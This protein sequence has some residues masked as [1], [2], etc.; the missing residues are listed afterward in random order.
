MRYLLTYLLLFLQ[1]AITIAQNNISVITQHNDLYRT[2]WNKNETILNPANVAPG[3]FGLIASLNVDD[4]V[5]AQVLIVHNLTIGNFTGNVLFA[6]TVNNSVYAFNA[7]DVSYG[8]PLWQINLNP[9]GQRAPDIFDLKD[10]Q[11]GQPCGGNYRD[12]SGRMGIVG[13]PVIDT[14]SN[15]L[16][17]ATKTIDA[18][19]N[20]YAYLN[21]LDI[22]TGNPKTG[23]PH[24]IQAEVDGTGDGSVNGKVKFLAKYQNQRPALLLYN[25]TVYTAFASHCDWGPYHGWV[26]GFD[27]ATLDLK[28]SYNAT[29]NGW[30]AGIWMAGEGISVGD[31]GNLYLTTG[32]G[33]TSAD[34]NNLTGGRSESLVKLSPQLQ[35]L[36]WFTPANYQYLDQLDLDYGCD[37][38]LIVP[39]SSITIS[40]SKEGV[41]YVVDYNN[42]GR[43]NATNS[44]VK[45][46]LE[47][48]PTHQGFVHVHGS[49]VYSKLNNQEFVYAWAESFKI[50]QFTF[51][52]NTGTF[53]DTFKQGIRN[54][55]NGMPGAMLSISSNAEDASS[56][57]VWGCFP[58]S[59]NANNQVRPGTIAAYAAS[60]VSAGELWNSDMVAQDVL[61]NF[62]K[63]N[64]PTVANG[65]VYVPTF[66]KS[67]QVYGVLCNTATNLSYGNGSGLE[68]E[69]FTNSTANSP[70][71]SP[72]LTRLDNTINFNW[73]S[74]SPATAISNDNFKVRWTGKLK[75][76]TDD[77]YTIYV[78]ASDG[79]R[80]WINN[81]LLIDSW[82]DKPVTVLSATIPLQKANDNDIRLEYYSNTNASSCILQWSA[83]GICKQNI[84]AS[85]LFPA[86]VQCSSNGTGLTAEY[87]SNSTAD[88]SY[89]SVASVTTTVPTV[90]FDW[91]TGSPQ[92]VSNDNFRARFSGYVQSLDSGTYTFY[93]TGDDGI[94]LWVN[95]QLLIN[96][97]IDQG[98]TEYTASIHLDQCTKYP[99]M[100]EYYE[101]GGQA[102]CQ[103]QWSG[104]TVGKQPI[105]AERFF[106]Q[107]DITQSGDILVYPNPVS[108]QDLT[109]S[110]KNPFQAGDKI[111]IYDM[112]GQLLYSKS[113][114]TNSTDNKLTIHAQQWSNGMYILQVKNGSGNHSVKFIVLNK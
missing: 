16:Y 109:V 4:E 99:I 9:Q 30:A 60:D 65:K 73:G 43:F 97:W 39:N 82:T 113:I 91:G 59:G 36:D 6:A 93:L 54:L 44:Q 96:K 37:G 14:I 18:N 48:N 56:A 38:V 79:V 98:A 11:Q 102:V 81:T 80:L 32:N 90:Y 22:K 108:S 20:F 33:T 8:A 68:G 45:D 42:M 62:A 64:S 41:S 12:F 100:V 3:K 105:P 35:L 57:I 84:P 114:T 34:N 85:Q 26:L 21:A 17:V 50:R 106:E 101:K 77:V 94:R 24:L 86:T 5:Y 83:Q 66:S 107:P 72:A 31:D 15:T 29:P 49:P 52:R 19:G 10:P 27:A 74:A 23:S 89:P 71:T 53:S 58:F 51:N 25:N 40:G 104:P 47:F 88:A 67:V 103:L 70:F 63:F 2:G 111:L 55:D 92:G 75:S 28:Y 13:T 76:L 61:G 69:Y 110:L 95:N 46:T 112:L 1:S 78:T 87:F 7:D